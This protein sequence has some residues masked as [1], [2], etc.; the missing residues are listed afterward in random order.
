[1]CMYVL[2]FCQYNEKLARGLH[3][4]HCCTRLMYQL[5]F[6]LL[7]AH[8]HIHRAPYGTLVI[9]NVPSQ[10]I[11]KPRSIVVLLL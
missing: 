9:D 1:M 11:I 7:L 6:Y 8:V 3:S 10:L 5:V 2:A 4:V